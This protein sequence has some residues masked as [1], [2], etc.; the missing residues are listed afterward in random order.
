MPSLREFG[1]DEFLMS[2]E[3]KIVI[4][5]TP[6]DRVIDLRHAVLRKGLPRDEAIFAGDELATSLHIAAETGGRVVGCATFHLNAW[7]GGPAY[8]LRGMATDESVRRR[9]VGR[10]MLLFAERELLAR[11]MTH[12]LWCNAR[13]P[14]VAFYQSMGWE[15]VSEVFEIPTAGPH[16][17]MVRRLVP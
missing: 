2:A 1:Y 8:Q 14:A 7:Q 6:V 15:G 9:G 12:Q 16:V 3:E 11:A 10:S 17:K 13:L 4:A 5:V